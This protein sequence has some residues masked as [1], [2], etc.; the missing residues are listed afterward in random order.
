M[1]SKVLK[2]A[3]NAHGGLQVYLKD[4]FIDSHLKDWIN[5]FYS[6]HSEKKGGI[7]IAIRN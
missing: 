1:Q 5:Q 2:L 3:I 7:Q 6:F 4:S